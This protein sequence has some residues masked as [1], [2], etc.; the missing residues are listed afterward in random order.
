MMYM[1]LMI[2]AVLFFVAPVRRFVFIRPMMGLMKKAMPSISPTEQVAIDAGTV[3]WE[4][5]LFRGKPDWQAL[6]AVEPAQ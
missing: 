1:L 6:S 4:K 5:S 3:W 2:L